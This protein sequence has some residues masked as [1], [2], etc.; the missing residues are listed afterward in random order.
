MKGV[1][2]VPDALS[3]KAGD[4]VF[5]V[6]NQEPTTAPEGVTLHNLVIPGPVVNGLPTTPLATSG[7][8]HAGTSGTF[9][10]KGLPGGTY[11]FYCSY[12]HGP[13]GMYG[14]LTVTG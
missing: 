5:F 11:Q 10:V 7:D 3:A 13:G 12:H 6:S 8:F 14:T 9:S 4:V 1:S 2:Y